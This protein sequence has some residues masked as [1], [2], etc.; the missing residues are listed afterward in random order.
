MTY[1][2]FPFFPL[3]YLKLGAFISLILFM[4][5]WVKKRG[6]KIVFSTVKQVI[7]SK[8]Q[9]LLNNMQLSWH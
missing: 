5:M 7:S 9:T 6:D 1:S 3:R 8:Y 4:K 2:I